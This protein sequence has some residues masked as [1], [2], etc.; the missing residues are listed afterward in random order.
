MLWVRATV[1]P[2]VFQRYQPYADVPG[3]LKLYGQKGVVFKNA[4]K[5]QRTAKISRDDLDFKYELLE[6]SRKE[7]TPLAPNNVDTY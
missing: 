1:F 3:E 5:I 6:L 4:E 2:L 7:C